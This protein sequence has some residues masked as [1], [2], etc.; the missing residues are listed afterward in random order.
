MMV[1]GPFVYRLGPQVF[2]LVRGVR[3]PY[4]LQKRFQI[5]KSLFFC[6]ILN[7]NSSLLNIS[8]LL[9]YIFCAINKIK[10]PHQKYLM[11]NIDYTK[12]NLL[13]LKFHLNSKIDKDTES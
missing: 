10:V 6:N 12:Q 2:I 4:G 1:D 7:L 9:F 5:L 3:L 13:I 8:K 11:R